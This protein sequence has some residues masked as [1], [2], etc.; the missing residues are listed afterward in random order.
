METSVGAGL[1][2][3]D[4][5]KQ[6]T[7]SALIVA[8]LRLSLERGLSDTTVEDI[9]AAVDVSSRTFFNYFAS[10]DDALVGDYFANSE[11]IRARLE[12]AD[13]GL[14]LLSA[15]RLAVTPSIERMHEE[16]ELWFLRMQ[17]ICKNP[18]LMPRL[19]A[20]NA[21][22]EEAITAAVAART[23]SAADSGF[24]ALVTAVAGAAYRTA[25]TRWALCAGARQ[26][27]ELVDEAFAAVATGLTQPAHL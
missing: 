19:L 9:S 6:Q 7:R 14:P 5:K 26:L 2:R 25:V 17:V 22:A 15:L 4:R 11:D 8:A 24:P 20:R 16:R 21:A 18:S 1:G 23:G 3:R 10:R 12:A 27:D 13:P